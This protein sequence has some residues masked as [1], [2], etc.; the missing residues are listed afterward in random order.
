[1]ENRK[2]N[3]ELS[4]VEIPVMGEEEFAEHVH[5]IAKN[6]FITFNAYSKFK[7]VNRAIKR[8]LVSPLGMIYPKRPFNNR[9][10]TL[11]R[12]MNTEK[13]RIYERLTQFT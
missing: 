1:M 4:K 5:N 9:K 10:E 3:E 12:K 11:G 8:G 6:K 7:S 13:K 2:K